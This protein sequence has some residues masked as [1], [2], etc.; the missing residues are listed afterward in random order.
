MARWM[1]VA[2]LAVAVVLG[3]C[4]GGKGEPQELVIAVQPTQQAAEMMEKARPIERF[5]EERL[6]GVDV[7]IF[8]P[9]SYAAVVEAL[10]FGQ[11]HVAFMSAWPSLLATKEAGAH[12]VLAEVRQVM[13]DGQQVEA[14]YYFS[15]WIVLKESPYQSLGELRGKRACFPSPIST[16]G[17]VAPMGRL[18]ELGL[19]PQ[20]ASGEEADPKRFFSDV[21]FGG[22]YQQCWQALKQGQVDV[23][24]MAGDVSQQLYQE[25]MAAS[26]VLESQ[27]PLPSHG[28]VVNKGLK[29]PLRAQVIDALMALGN[30]RP[31][32]M[33]GFVSAIFVRFQPTTLQ[34]HLGQLSRYL[35]LTGLQFRER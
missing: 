32:L 12:L 19:L 30:E 8:V 2:L 11:A 26:R 34:E 20:P 9:T 16:S 35:Q 1:F 29:D 5:L 6:P 27:G 28:V 22:G 10:R 17:Y 13:R 3:G 24:V 33:R 18:V 23:T 15:H 7:K 14:P 21:V 31:E 4:G 25:A